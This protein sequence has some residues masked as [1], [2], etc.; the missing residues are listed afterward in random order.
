MKITHKSRESRKITDKSRGITQITVQGN[1]SQKRSCEK[2]VKIPEITHKARTQITVSEIT[3]KNHAPKSRTEKSRTESLPITHKTQQCQKIAVLGQLVHNGK[4]Q[5]CVPPLPPS[6]AHA[7]VAVCGG[8]LCS[9]YS[10]TAREGGEHGLLL[11]VCQALKRRQGAR[12]DSPR[13]IFRSYRRQHHGQEGSSTEG[14]A[15][16]QVPWRC[17]VDGC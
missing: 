12:S 11:C 16:P 3:R 7:H 10:R 13:R 17:A 4:T 15:G 14:G 2:H 5:F 6:P 8:L 1:H 9:C